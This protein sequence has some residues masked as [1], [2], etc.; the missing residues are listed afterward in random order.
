[1]YGND[2]VPQTEGGAGTATPPP[3]ASIEPGLED[4][5]RIVGEDG[6]IEPRDVMPEDYRSSLIR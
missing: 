6:R 2:F 1:M 5:W 4:F 3:P